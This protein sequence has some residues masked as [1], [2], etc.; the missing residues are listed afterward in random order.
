MDFN[1]ISALDNQLV[2]LSTPNGGSMAPLPNIN[3]A[4]IGS[5]EPQQSKDIINNQKI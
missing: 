3:P 2:N 4:F 5:E 1:N